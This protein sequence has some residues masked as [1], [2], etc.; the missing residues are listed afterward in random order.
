MTELALVVILKC[1]LHRLPV[2][3]DYPTA[4]PMPLLVML[5]SLVVFVPHVARAQAGSPSPVVPTAPSAPAP[6]P[7][8]AAPAPA[9]TE[10]AAPANKEIQKPKELGSQQDDRG[11]IQEGFGKRWIAIPTISS[12]PKLSTAFGAM[13]IVFLR[14]DDSVA[15]QIALG[16]NY[17]ISKSWT[18]FTFGS[19]NFQHDRQRLMLGLFR[20]HAANSYDNFMN[21]GMALESQSNILAVPV[22][23]LHRLADRSKT[24]WWAGGQIIYVKLDQEGEEPTSSDL[25]ESLGLDG[26]QALQW[27]PNVQ[28]DSRDNTNSPSHGQRLFLRGGP[29]AQLEP[30]DATPFF[31]SVSLDYSIYFPLKYLVL[32]ANAGANFTFGAPLIFQSSLSQF[33]GYTVGEDLAKHSI[34][35]QVE[36]RIPFGTTRFGAAAFGGVAT[37]FDDFSDWGELDTYNPMGGAGLRFM[38]N[39]TQKSIVR[40]EYAQGVR[41]ARGI[42]LAMSQPFK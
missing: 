28:Y 10:N 12:N 24:D 25:I 3:G 17:S 26:A 22:M 13:A 16:G 27:G 23:Y 33:R 20:G 42:Y 38:I 11:P 6:A 30:N 39:K 35:A 19:F 1:F 40:L 37:L 21:L 41:G 2:R 8:A 5:L 34:M 18:A 31:G 14:L 9:A 7:A 32:A 4:M 15:S 29:W 36:A